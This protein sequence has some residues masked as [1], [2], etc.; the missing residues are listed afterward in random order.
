MEKITVPLSQ[1]R[2]TLDVQT[3]FSDTDAMGHINNAV[4][5][6][7]LELGRMEYVK[8]VFGITSFGKVGFILA[9][10][11]IDYRT[12]AFVG[13]VLRVGTRVVRLGGAS[14]TMDYRIEEASSGRL[15]AAAQSVQV[16][17]DYAA[18]KVKKNSEEFL[19]K[20]RRHDGLA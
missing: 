4:Y 20:V 17:Y 9:R 14:F 6:S 1:Y 10:V 5:L 7:Y 2:T 19:T 11:E 15:V 12:P 16:S 18:G 8:Q 3:R 13:E